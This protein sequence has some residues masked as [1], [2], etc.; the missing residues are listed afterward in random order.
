M[1]RAWASPETAIERARELM[2]SAWFDRASLVFESLRGD[3]AVEKS[4]RR[5]ERSRVRRFISEIA[6]PHLR[7]HLRAALDLYEQR[8]PPWA[9]AARTPPP[10][11]VNR[12]EFV[13]VLAASR[14]AA[15][16]GF[17]GPSAWAYFEVGR[18]MTLPRGMVEWRRLVGSWGTQLRLAGVGS[19]A[20]R[21]RQG[22]KSNR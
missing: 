11:A 9:V 20:A 22:A 15:D 3:G 5:T 10:D 12:S 2:P 14:T 18:G 7:D 6:E 19:E 13:R 1:N 17:P 21:K 4:E 16:L 8:C